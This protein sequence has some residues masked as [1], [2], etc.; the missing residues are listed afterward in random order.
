M[1]MRLLL[2][3]FFFVLAPALLAVEQS[4]G[5]VTFSIPEKGFG[6]RLVE[7]GKSERL[8]STNLGISDG[9]ERRMLIIG[10]E[11]PNVVSRVEALPGRTVI[12]VNYPVR[13]ADSLQFSAVYRFYDGIPGVTV[14]EE[15]LA[16]KPVRVHSWNM[17]GRHGFARLSPDGRT[18]QDFPKPKDFKAFYPALKAMKKYLLATTDDRRVFY[19]D[20][21]FRTL[22]GDFF[23]SAYPKALS[24]TEGT[25]LEPGETMTMTHTVGRPLRKEDVAAIAS[26]PGRTLF[27]GRTGPIVVTRLGEKAGD[28]G[29]DWGKVPVVAR[30]GESRDYRPHATNQWKGPQDLSFELKAA[31]DDENL[32]LRIDVADDESHN[33]YQ[34][35]NLWLG[36]AVQFG[37]DPLQEKILGPNHINLLVAAADRGP[38]AWCVTHPNPAFSGDVGKAIRNRSRLRNGGAV[39]ELAFPWEFLLPFKP[40]DGVFGMTFAVCDQDAGTSCETWMGLTDGVLGGHDAALYAKFALDGL[41]DLSSGVLPAGGGKV[42]RREDLLALHARVSALK[43]KLDGK[44]GALAAA[45][46]RDDYLESV[47]EMTRHFLAFERE[48]L[49]AQKVPRGS[50]DVEVTP[51]LRAYIYGRFEYNL[52]YLE[53]LLP[54]LV[55]RA[56]ATLAGAREPDR[57]VA[58]ERGVRPQIEDGGFRVKGRELLLYGPNTWL[59][60]GDWNLTRAYHLETMARSGFNFFNLFNLSE[61]VRTE[62]MRL[63]ERES[64]Y[65]SFGSLTSDKLTLDETAWRDFWAGID[66]RPAGHGGSREKFGY[67]TPNMVFQ[68]AFPEQFGRSYEKTEAWAE[69][70]RRH[71]LGRFGSLAGVNAALGTSF[72]DMKE[73]DFAK[74]VVTPS[75]KYESMRFRLD[76]HVPRETEHLAFKRTRFDNLPISGHYSTHWNIAGLDPLLSLADFERI[77]SMYEVVGYDGGCSL[78]ETEFVINFASGCFEVDFARSVCPEKPLA[79]NEDHVIPDGVYRHYTDEESYLAGALPFFLG[80]NAASMWLWC[81]RYHRD[82]DYAFTMANTYHA[83]LRTA[84]ELRRAPEEI[85]SFRRTPEPPFRMLHSVPS[86]TDRDSYVSSLYGLYAG[87]SFS[88]WAVRFVTEGLLEEAGAPERCRIIFVPDARRVSDRTFAALEKFAR[89][90]GRVVAVGREPLLCDEYGKP[91]PSR[92]AVCDAQFHRTTS[93]STRDYA[94]LLESEL[95]KADGAPP[96]SVRTA[97]GDSPFGVLTRTGRTAD[98]RQTLLAVNLLKK[99]VDVTLPGKWRDVLSGRSMQGLCKLAVGEALVLVRGE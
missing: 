10:G 89:A 84:C 15:L 17:T 87:L 14:T 42:L 77:W 94:K 28:G 2:S 66:A 53:R 19:Y 40:S 31:Y 72:G 78:G 86:M 34:R 59:A 61:P 47:R 88:G 67:A 48:D 33:G 13:N 32:Y 69:D 18:A 55:S 16:L 96:V 65:C 41:V 68:T 58:Y 8:F 98:G 95:E 39:Y 37:I 85:T 76:Q 24:V 6:V 43:E 62:T 97:S 60:G 56:D 12:R 26:L 36:D 4:V 99:P 71:L 80:Q 46:R 7:G 75:L 81:P 79:N 57:F 1:G 44:C 91:V 74:A 50:K 93:I 51:E 22:E 49:D 70:F 5:G 11:E 38:R 92:Q 3:F 83:A 27:D 35:G 52:G 90:G 23:Y 82:G 25:L 45:G 54:G 64:L 20:R 73:I 30:R 9:R 21:G 29:P 63:A